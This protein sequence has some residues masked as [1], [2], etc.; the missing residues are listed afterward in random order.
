MKL[1]DNNK[2]TVNEKILAKGPLGLLALGDIG[3]RKWKEAKKN[4]TKPTK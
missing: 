4:T 3:I 2:D 1:Y